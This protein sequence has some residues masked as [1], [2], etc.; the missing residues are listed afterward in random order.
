MT[1]KLSVAVAAAVLACATTASATHFSFNQHYVKPT[2]EITYN[3]D[4]IELKLTG[5]KVDKHGNKIGDALIATYTSSAGGAGVCS[6]VLNNHRVGACGH[7]EHTIDGSGNR[8]MAVLDFGSTKVNI[9]SATFAYWDSNDD[10]E[11]AIYDNGAGNSP[12]S[13]R[14][15]VDVAGHGTVTY[16]FAE[17][18]MGSVF[19][20]GSDWKHDEFKLQSVKVEEVMPPIAPVPLPAGGLLLAAALGGLALRRRS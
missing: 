10:F 14:T 6:G 13:Y 17:G 11:F 18:V 7:D 20:I 1:I 5:N 4:G 3:V 12:T 2:D 9:L 16:T 8:E 19:G 15:D